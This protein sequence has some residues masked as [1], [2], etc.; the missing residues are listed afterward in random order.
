ME[1]KKRRI[2]S[3][4]MGQLVLLL[5][6][7]FTV[8]TIIVVLI[9]S[10]NLQKRAIN[11][12]AR[13][14]ARQTS[15]LVFQSL[16][17]A[18]RKGWTKQEIQ[19]IIQRL[20]R[21]SPE[22]NIRVFRGD[23]VIRQFG[24]IPGEREVRESDAKI[25]SALAGGGEELIP[26]DDRIRYIY[27][28]VVRQE[29][30]VCHTAARPGDING[31]IDIV[32]PIKNLKI[33]LEYLTRIVLGF[34]IVMLLFLFLGLYFKL[35]TFIVRP[36]SHFVSVIQDIIQNTDLTR[37]VEQKSRITELKRLTEYFNRLISTLQNYQEKL[38]D[39]SIRDPLTDLYNRRKFEQFLE[40]EIDRS[41]R[42]EH[43]FTLIMLDLDNFKHINDTY[44]HPVGDLALKELSMALSSNKRK[45]DILAR[46]GGDEFAIILPETSLEQ[47]IHVAEKVR[48]MLVETDLELPMGFIRIHASIG[49]VSFPEN[50]HDTERMGIAMDV[51]MYKAKRLGKNQVATIDS[52]DREVMMEVFKQGEFLRKALDEDR[53]E[54]HLQPIIR[55][56]S[57]SVY[58]YEVLARIR[59]NGNVIPAGNFVQIAEELGYAE[60]LDRRV[61]FKGLECN[62][63][64]GA[65]NL[66]LFFNFSPKTFS[67]MEN[68]RS[69][70][71]I[72]QKEGVSPHQVVI[73]I[74]EREALP[75]I[76]ELAPIMEELKKHGMGF[77]LDD[78]GSGFSSFMYLKYLPVDYVK[79][80]GSFVRHMMEDPRDRI[81]VKNIHSMAREFGLQTI[82]EFVESEEVHELL[83]ELGVDHAQGY[84]YARPAPCEAYV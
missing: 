23:P 7:G 29:C 21:T 56:E 5:S 54:A 9:I 60:E 65:P 62:K 11:D 38:E 64:I 70:P 16:Y 37:R 82:A 17:S 47:G 10:I 40:Y 75:H 77:A 15:R 59:E 48:N 46:L 49:V 57:G 19:E 53:V 50:G 55:T 6:F 3:I 18:M 67:H 4:T 58:G 76:A 61:L 78:F 73:E 35:R 68:I 8:I 34:F 66:K 28:I 72:I 12:L 39:L 69:L 26:M 52:S 33:S 42:H 81:M 1:D 41:R 43:N 2:K 22:M 14:D 84:Y 71:G 79:I 13:Q 25:R 80:E 24:E 31:V 74:T 32:Y 20:N 63:Q 45:T 27:P 51:A 36:V 30:V 44:G 83:K